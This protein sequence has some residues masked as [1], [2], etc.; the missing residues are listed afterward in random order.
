MK[1]FP[2]IFKLFL[3]VFA[4]L[5]FSLSAIASNQIV[6]AIQP[7][8]SFDGKIIDKIII[9]IKKTYK[10]DVIILSDKNLPDYAYYKPRNRYRAEKLLYFLDNIKERNFIKIL[11]L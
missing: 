5:A 4:L 8:G 7:L 2:G 1:K 3:L 11:G 10:A 6:I 9:S